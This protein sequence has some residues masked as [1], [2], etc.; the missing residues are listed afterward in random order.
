M[1]ERILILHSP[2]LHW[3]FISWNVVLTRR[4]LV[5]LIGAPFVLAISLLA[6]EP[7][8]TPQEESEPISYEFFSGTVTELQ[9]GKLTVLRTLPGKSPEKHT[10]ILKPD[11]RI[12]GRLKTRARVTVGYISTDEGYVALRVVVRQNL[13]QR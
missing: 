1:G 9:P 12:E 8:Q 13:P 11:T 6:A 10:F 4:G 3:V 7:E 5:C 2:L